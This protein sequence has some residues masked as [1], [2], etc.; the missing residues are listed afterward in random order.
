MTCKQSLRLVTVV[1]ALSAVV[2][3]EAL[4][5]MATPSSIMVMP[6]RR[7]LVDLAS[8]IV[9]IKDVGLVAYDNRPDLAEPVLH[10]WNGSEWL[11]IAMDDYVAGNF[12]SGEPRN[13]ILLGDG[14][15]LP[16]RMAT[17]PAWCRNVHRVTTLDTATL[18][19]E[20]NKA[21][22]FSST[23]WRW[24]A[25]QNGLQLIDHNAERRRYGRWGASGAGV[26]PPRNNSEK[27]EMP[28]SAPMGLRE[29]AAVTNAAVPAREDVK[30]DIPAVEPPIKDTEAVPA[31]PEART[32]AKA[33]PPAAQEKPD[34]L[35]VDGKADAAPAVA[36]QA[37]PIETDKTEPAKEGE[38][39]PPPAP[40]VAAPQP[41]A[42]PAEK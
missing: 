2:I 37:A 38:T 11:Q 20:L 12:M 5:G 3:A 17:A 13:L 40:A 24:L 14:N 29:N 42:E 34:A 23:E 26:V 7:R 28:P 1:A 30:V 39:A 25:D 10:I 41:V 21:L 16:A 32:D 9:R 18:L 6:A 4:A 19:N 15:T 33:E 36:E 8:Q 35:A 27:L 31:A 22:K